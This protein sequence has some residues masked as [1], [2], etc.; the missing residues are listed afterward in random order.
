[1]SEHGQQS[2]LSAGHLEEGPVRG[3]QDPL[4]LNGD[5][6]LRAQLPGMD[7]CSLSDFMAAA[8][9]GDVARVLET[10][11]DGW[12]DL[13]VADRPTVR[14]AL[15]KFP[16]SV[17]R[18]SP[19]LAMLAGTTYYSVPH[20]RIR[21]LR[22]FLVAIRAASSE[23]R[24]VDE[25]DRALI[26]TAASVSYRLIGQPKQGLQAAGRALQILHRMSEEK[27]DRV[28][29]LSVL[30][31][32]LGTTLY[33]GGRVADALDTFE[34]GLAAVP[35]EGDRQGFTNLS[36]LAGI[37]ALHG[38]LPEAEDYLELARDGSWTDT[39]RLAYSGTF[40]RLAEAIVALERFDAPV[41]WNHLAA[42]V[43]DRRTIEHWIPIAI[44][45]AGVQLAAGRPGAALAGLDAFAALRRR[46]GRTAVTRAELAPTRALLQLALGNPD[47]A[48]AILRR[49]AEPSPIRSVGLARVELARD[50]HGAALQHVRSLAG[51]QLSHRLAAEL[52]TIEAAVLLRFSSR[53]RSR[54]VIDHLGNILANTAQRLP[55]LLVPDSDFQQLRSALA[56][57]GHDAVVADLPTTSFFPAP[58]VATLLSD[59]ERAVL[60]ELLLTPSTAMIAA[61]LVVSV[62]T[63]KTQLKSIYRKL[64]VSSRD[65]A[66]AVALDRHL[67]TGPDPDAA[68]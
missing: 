56:E 22:L 13:L 53:A 27:R 37:H 18:D 11:R 66:V 20:Y 16:T 45:E 23:R 58:E 12:L 64:G 26:L 34:H 54:G 49:D 68:L 50:H 67:V 5:P 39:A 59:R 19:L 35:T 3:Y 9:E 61:E 4:G 62:N 42:M 32:Q 33:Y 63:V 51:S 52:A 15:E 24:G 41:A 30:Y 60:R 38:D 55:V 48:L 43:H 21:G 10:V 28:S 44:T 57:A 17:I 7:G 65:E 2:I 14:G 29:T 46:E 36:M 31:S 1:M 8:E 47:D 6:Q 25:I 40:Y